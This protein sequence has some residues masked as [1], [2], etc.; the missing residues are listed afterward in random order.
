MKPGPIVICTR[1]GMQVR[2]TQAWE[3]FSM[4]RHLGT[5]GGGRQRTLA[6]AGEDVYFCTR[7]ARDEDQRVRGLAATASL[8]G[9]E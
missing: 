4:L 9:D 3:R 7:C 2:R 8:F 5:P 6:G 1:C